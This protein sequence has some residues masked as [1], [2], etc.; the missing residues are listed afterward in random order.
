MALDE[1]LFGKVA[2][3]FKEKK[4]VA[5]SLEDRAVFLDEVKEK[6][7][8]LACA[9]TGIKIDVHGAEREG[10]YK[11]NYFFLPVKVNLYDTREENKQFYVLDYLFGN[12]KRTRF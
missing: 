1:Y 8:V 3:Y 4:K 2:K 12:S 9:V 10:G 7:T 11:N 6:L 5:Q